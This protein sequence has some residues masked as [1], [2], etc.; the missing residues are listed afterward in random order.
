M[1]N[2][3][4]G[5]LEYIVVEGLQR[6]VCREFISCSELIPLLCVL[7]PTRLMYRFLMLSYLI[8]R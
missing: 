1:K 4:Y 8:D 3:F 2:N 5:T 6:D 7:I